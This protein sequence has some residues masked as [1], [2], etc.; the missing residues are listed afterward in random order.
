VRCRKILLDSNDN[1]PAAGL[2]TMQ[3]VIELSSDEEEPAPHQRPPHQLSDVEYDDDLHETPLEGTAIV[4]P[5]QVSDEDEGSVDR[6][7]EDAPEAVPARLL[8]RPISVMTPYGVVEKMGPNEYES[9]EGYS[10]AGYE[11]LSLEEKWLYHPHDQCETQWQ[12]SRKT[13][14]ARFH[15]HFTDWLVSFVTAKRP[16]EQP[17]VS[18]A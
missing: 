5:L 9:E 3:E 4:E 18:S 8:A 13:P 7:P 10:P 1:N 16:D 17:K 15:P 6:M 12:L 2:T 11:D 14:A